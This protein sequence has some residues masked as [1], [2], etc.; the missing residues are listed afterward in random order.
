MSVLA[1][2]AIA[3]P[4]ITGGSFRIDR[5]VLEQAEKKY[6]KDARVRLIAWEDLIREDTSSSDREKLEKVNRFH[7]QMNFVDDMR[8]WG[9][10]DY[11]ATPIEF[12]ASQGGDCEDF[13]I[14]KYFTLKAMGVDEEK[15]NLTYV[16]ALQY[17]MHHMVM[18]YYSTPGAEPLVLDNLVE[19]I[20]PG[21]QRT[22]LMPIFSFNGTGLWLAKQRGRGKLAGSSSRVKRWRDLL[23]K[24]SQNK[25]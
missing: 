11:W 14:A 25:L 13:S 7:N 5:G 9:Q 21:S 8:H 1:V 10:E 15:L 17:N 12:L 6:G 18:T 20:K 22:D 4:V 19:S 24:M 2:L 23:E 16:K 3:G